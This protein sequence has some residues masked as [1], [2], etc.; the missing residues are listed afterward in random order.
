MEVNSMKQKLS[1]LL[2]VILLLS[3]FSGRFFA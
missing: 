1:I 3:L 2:A